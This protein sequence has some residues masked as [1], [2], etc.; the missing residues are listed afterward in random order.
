MHY[1]NG[2]PAKDG[3]AVITKDWNGKVV[4]GT[5]HSTNAQ[6]TTCNGQVAVAVPGGVLQGCFTVGEMFSA[7]EA[8]AAMEAKLP[9]AAAPEPVADAAN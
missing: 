4:A 9:V 6:S 3:D 1:K 8:F 7:A 2:T 5:L